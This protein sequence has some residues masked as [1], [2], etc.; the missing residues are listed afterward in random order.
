MKNIN[1]DTESPVARNLYILGIRTDKES[2]RLIDEICKTEKC[3]RSDLVLKSIRIYAELAANYVD[4]P[5]PAG[6]ENLLKLLN[7]KDACK[8]INMILDDIVPD[9]RE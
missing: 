1:T 2:K 7:L 4:V 9:D 5:L 3:S 8:T 6:R